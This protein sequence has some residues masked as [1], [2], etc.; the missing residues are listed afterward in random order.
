MI[1]ILLSS[2]LFMTG[3]SNLEVSGAKFNLSFT[4]EM[5]NTTTQVYKQI[6]SNISSF[7]S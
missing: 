4:P 6:A 1:G 5:A 2:N 7:V 3:L